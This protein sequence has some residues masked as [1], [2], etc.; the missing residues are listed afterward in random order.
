MIKTNLKVK[1]APGYDMITGH[2]LKELPQS[3]F[4][5][6]TSLFNAVLRTSYFPAQWKVA[7]II[8]IPKPGKNLND[9]KS[10]RPISLL[11][12]VSKVFEKLFY[13]RIM[14]FVEKDALIP[15]HQFGFRQHHATIE[16]THRLVDIIQ[17]S[18][19]QKKYNSVAFIDITQAFDKVWHAGLLYKLKKCFPSSFYTVLKT[20]IEDRSFLL[21]YEDETSNLYPMHSGVPQGSILG[22]LLYVI[23]TRDLPS[24][25]GCEIATFA[26]DT[27]VIAVN[28]D[29]KTASKL[30]QIN[31]NKLEQW[32]KKWRIKVN[33]AKCVHVTFTTRRGVCPP[34]QLSGHQLPIAEEAK[35]LGIHL[36]RSLTWKKHIFTKR[37][38]LGLKLRNM[39]WLLGTSSPL[40]IQLKV[41]IYNTILK[42][43]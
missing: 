5:F 1:K 35:Y 18:F 26:D 2:I 41:L 14:M 34:V 3:G 23:F 25:Q 16:Q 29:P 42:P 4:K 22:P 38:Q 32:F 37:K 28:D 9:V 24:S 36:D 21:K 8:M 33:S 20:Y 6:L 10:Y 40:S 15:N 19:E 31:L 7:T 17:S 39:F 12:V 27:A 13:K 30:L 11:P 43:V